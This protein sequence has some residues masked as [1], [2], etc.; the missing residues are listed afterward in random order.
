MQ[1]EVRE[2]AETHGA[3]LSKESWGFH[4]HF[5][6]LYCE[7]WKGVGSDVNIPVPINCNP[8]PS[9]APGSGVPGAKAGGQMAA[10]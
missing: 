7:L 8:A 4:L 6:H 2:E 5:W 3:G 10:L 9:V 1:P